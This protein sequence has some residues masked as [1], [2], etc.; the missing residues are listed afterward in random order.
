MRWRHRQQQQQRQYTGA[1]PEH[2]LIAA[3]MQ[4]PKYSWFAVDII[5]T[6]TDVVIGAA[7]IATAITSATGTAAVARF[8]CFNTISFFFYFRT[9]S[10]Q[11]VP[12]INFLDFSSFFFLFKLA[13]LSLPQPQLLL[14]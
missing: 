5:A 7:A 6:G 10:L 14:L 11:K 3:I 12:I 9:I 4:R 8:Q 2:K 1:V 13:M